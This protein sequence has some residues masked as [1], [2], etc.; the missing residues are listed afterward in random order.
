MGVVRLEGEQLEKARATE[1]LDSK[2]SGKSGYAPYQTV[3][4]AA[5]IQ[6]WRNLRLRIQTPARARVTLQ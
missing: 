4:P 1:Q 3:T 2:D 6:Q 5:P